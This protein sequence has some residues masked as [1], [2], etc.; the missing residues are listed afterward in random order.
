[1]T[2][3]SLGKLTFTIYVDDGSLGVIV[4]SM[5]ECRRGRWYERIAVEAALM[6]CYTMRRLVSMARTA[7]EAPEAYLLNIL[8]VRVQP[9]DAMS[10]SGTP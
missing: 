3:G 8:L 1:M 4:P 9:I 7:S 6:K 2:D 10:E 5:K